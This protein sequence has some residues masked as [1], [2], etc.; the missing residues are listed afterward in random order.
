MADSNKNPGTADGCCSS[1]IP[2]KSN[3]RDPPHYQKQ[4]R[5]S[6]DPQTYQ[7]I[8]HVLVDQ[9]LPAEARIVAPEKSLTLFNLQEYIDRTLDAV[10][11]AEKAA[12]V[13]TT[14]GR[15]GCSEVLFENSGSARTLAVEPDRLGVSSLSNFSSIRANCCVY[16]GKWI[17]E[18]ML[19]S[20]GVMQVGW[21][22]INCQ[23]FQE[24][25]VGD[26]TDSY[27]YDGNRLCKWNVKTQRYG[28]S[29]LTGDVISCAIDCDKGTIT[30]F[31][32]G[33]C[34]GEA[35]N[36]VR[37]G[38]GY[39]YFPAVSLSMSENVEGYKPL[40]DPPHLDLVQA[41]ILFCYLENLLPVMVEEESER[42][43]WSA[44]KKDL[45]P[46][47]LGDT[48][49]RQCNLLLVAAH[50]FNK[51]ATLL[52]SAYIVEACLLR[53]MLKVCDAESCLSEQPYISKLLDTMWTLM[54]DFEL[55]AC[56]ENLIITLLTAYRFSPITA[57]F[58]YPRMYLSLTLAILKHSQTRHHL[59]SHI[60]FPVFLHI[61]PPDD[62]GLIE[63]VPTVWWPKVKEEGTVLQP[64]TH[65][66]EEDKQAYLASCE[67]LKN[68]IEEIERLQVEM[69][70]VLLIHDDKKEP[71]GKTSRDLFLEKFRAFLKENAGTRLHPINTCPLPVSLCFFHRLIQALRYYWDFYAQQDTV[72]FLP[73][74]EAYM[75]IC[76][77]KKPGRDN[78]DFQRCGGLLS[79]LQRTLSDGEGN[80]T[81]KGHKS[82]GNS[83]SR[84]NSNDCLESSVDPSC[85]E[86][87]GDATLTELL[88]GVVTLYHIA[89]HKQL[90]KMSALRDNMNEFINSLIDTEEKL[91]KCPDDA[92]E[93]KYELERAKSV[94]EEKISE[95]GR[96]MAWVI[97]V[98]YSKTKQ[99]DVAWIFRVV[100]KTIEK[101]SAHEIPFQFLPEFYVDTCINSYNA[102]K[103]YFH[104]TANFF[105][106]PDNFDLSHKFALFLTRHFSDNRIV[107][108]DLRDNITQALACFACFPY[109]LEVLEDLPLESKKSMMHYLTAPYDNRSWAQTNWILV[110]IWKGCGFG[111]RYTHLPHLVPSKLQTTELGVASLQKPCPSKVFQDLLSEMLREDRERAIRFLDTMLSQLNWSFSE[112]IAI[113]QQ[114]QQVVSKTE[115]W[116]IDT[117]QLKFCATCFQITISLL[118]VVEMIVSISPEFFTDYSKSSSELL[119]TRLIQLLCQILNRIATRNG[120]FENVI[121]LPLPGMEVVTHYP[122]VAATVGILIRLILSSKDPERRDSRVCNVLLSE[123]LFQINSLNFLL[124]QD[125]CAEI[126]VTTYKKQFNLREISQVNS[127]EI[128]Q[129]EDLIEYLQNEIDNKSKQQKSLKDEDVCAICY[130]NPI[131]VIFDPCGHKSCRNCITYQMMNKKEC[132]Y[133]MTPVTSVRDIESND[134]DVT[135]TAAAAA[136]KVKPSSNN[137]TED[138]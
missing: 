99:I 37:C 24:N 127:E 110:R 130:A 47:A 3:N 126:D 102:L 124:G 125:E 46:P 60:K 91:A 1:A 123:P 58:K 82:D 56:L 96:Q 19:G 81:K 131:S 7:L 12:E 115:P 89:T 48:R 116:F 44:E 61:K 76:E 51:L 2:K 134:V 14:E 35:F 95:L 97:A 72:K 38:P 26:T 53:F 64:Q 78:L 129:V 13:S 135:S 54:Q 93:I 109:S 85:A 75:P 62:K 52:K 22:T 90:G 121:S 114:I 83:G 32:N 117:R 113:M 34:L 11:T 33:K 84:S 86:I 5:S 133:C 25:G 29:W 106:I 66:E 16:K 18:L 10:V 8:E 30:F 120:M 42:K 74:S 132:F 80:K 101:A 31:R 21:C 6:M 92:Q 108:S 27:A 59:L 111:Y 70:K 57:D 45:Q 71:Q 40:Q 49:S 17:Y 119:L 100:L 28:E 94:F 118:R 55:K 98:I 41:Q 104:P 69:L 67:Q 138:K 43:S 39:A 20:K 9:S 105:D 50:L 79:H 103:N 128:K 4:A 15:L 122:I 23:F 107:N 136:G 36:N 88:D 65:K 112:F 87:P 73:S 77:F 68:K 137:N 63:I